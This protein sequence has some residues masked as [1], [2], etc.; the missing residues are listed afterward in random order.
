MVSGR[1]S[2]VAGFLVVLTQVLAVVACGGANQRPSAPAQ[3]A[4]NLL[5]ITIDTLR[6]DRVGAYGYGSAQTPAMDRLA[7]EGVRFTRAFTTAPITLPAHASLLTGRYPPGHGARHNGIAMNTAIPTLATALQTAGF[8]TAAFVSAFPLDRR[9]GLTRG[10]DAYDDELPRGPD[11]KPLNERRGDETAQRAISWLGA[12]ASR[13][14][15]LWVHLFEPHAPYGDPADSRPVSSRYDDEIAAADRAVAH[16]L[17]ALGD[18]AA[19]TVVVL[20]A[21]HGEA[22]GE[23]GEI[24]HSIFVYDTTL[25]IPLIMRG[26]GLPPGVSIDVP[27]SL[28]DVAPTIL[29]LLGVPPF[30]VDG[31]S[32]QP[33][34]SSTPMGERTLYAESF[35]PL[36]DFGWSP[37]RSVREGPWKYI[38]APKAELYELEKD[39][40]ET[41]N[42]ESRDLQ[43]ASRLLA[44]VQ[45]YSSLE[46][47]DPG[48]DSEATNRLR[49][50]GYLGGATG[51]GPSSTRPDPKD[52]IQ[53]AS[54]LAE[55]TSGEVRGEALIATL[56]AIL[57]DDPA[58][59]QAHLRLG[60]AEIERNRCDR[61]V[62]HL[63]AALSARLP[64]AD[65]GLA[66]ADCRSRA[67][68][69]K[70]ALEAL[71][72]AQAL[73]PGNPVVEA[74]L[75]L[76]A[77]SRDD[78]ATAI[79]WLQSSLK[80]DPALLEARFALARA[81]GRA[82]RRQEAAAEARTLLSQ[83]PL[84]APQRREVERLLAALK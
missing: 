69:A 84:E 36:L 82:G 79:R 12:N 66:L 23:H 8:G 75:G 24:G 53:V 16:L 22:F 73:E 77:L 35:A 40:N 61:A 21:D 58:N 74:N 6:A 34:I 80:R 26:P 56:E 51:Q 44:R 55:V 14:T 45:S 67:N 68:D 81:L 10:F 49:S 70:G 9:F 25:R 60:Y 15:F 32:L 4:Q 48:S 64:S 27:V 20:A 63:R 72:A 47:P 30:D 41:V 33:A 62:P 7:R 1:R 46:P 39:P 17:G 83:L 50:L 11:R 29:P 57:K 65:A 42:L 52:R 3:A 19:S 31:V 2:P 37:L 78:V 18:H 13:R 28:V 59:P 38:A 54:R 5:L 76:L 71:E 43:R